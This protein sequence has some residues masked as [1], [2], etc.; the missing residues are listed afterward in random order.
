MPDQSPQN[1]AN[2]RSIDKSLH[3]ITLLLIIA[4]LLFMTATYLEMP[5]LS[6]AATFLIVI[7][8]MGI[9]FRMRVYAVRVQDRIIRLETRLRLERVLP[10]DLVSMIPALTLSQLIGLRFASD[11]ELPDLV[12]R[13]LDNNLTK[14]DEIKKLVKNWQ[15]DH[16]RV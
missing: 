5:A 3:L 8:I 12:R 16:L 11:E 14:S 6:I 1:Y 15:A 7:A 2:H 4:A 9:M 13:V 10:D